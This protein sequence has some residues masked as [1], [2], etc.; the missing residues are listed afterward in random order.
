MTIKRR[1]SKVYLYRN[2]RRGRR[3]VS[4]YL[5]SGPFAE[6]VGEGQEA[7]R[8]EAREARAAWDGE[9]AGIEAEDDRA[10][11]L[12]DLIGEVVRDA[13]EA[14]G[15][16]RHRS[17]GWRRRRQADRRGRPRRDRGGRVSP[18]PEWRVAEAETS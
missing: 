2:I 13:I 5:G 11:G 1:G 12:C 14:A 8:E 10:A 6:M 3:V 4:E 17:G 9:R 7:I 16:H 18:A 15:Y